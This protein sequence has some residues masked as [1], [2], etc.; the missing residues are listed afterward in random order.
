MECAPKHYLSAQTD[1]CLLREPGCRYDDKDNCVSCDEPF[2]YSHNKCIIPGCSK[3]S[4]S[5]C[6]Q[7]HKPYILSAGGYCEIEHCY[8]M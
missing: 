8:R 1:R 2:V 4:Y 5:G 7:C 6:L 3:L